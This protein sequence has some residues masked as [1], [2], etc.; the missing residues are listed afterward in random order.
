LDVEKDKVLGVTFF[1]GSIEVACKLA[2]KGGLLVAPSGPG[3]ASDLQNR[4]GYITALLSAQVCLLDSGLISLWSKFFRSK[5]LVRLSGLAFLKQYLK[6]TD[7]KKEKAFWVM[8]NQQDADQ[9]LAWLTKKYGFYFDEDSVYIAPNYPRAGTIEDIQLQEK[10]EQVD[11]CNIFIQIGGGVQERLG[12]FLQSKVK[13]ETSIL[14]TGA[15][16]A[17]LSGRQVKIPEWAD[18]CFLGWAFRCLANPRLF[19]PRYLKALKLVY[20]LA[21]YRSALPK[22]YNKSN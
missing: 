19:I 5:A 3:M 7:W 12:L 21:R 2:R 13:H 15:A 4:T 20:L 16:L 8:P 9:M 1:Q 17:F 10:I 22:L 18:F 6:N 11:P 14:C